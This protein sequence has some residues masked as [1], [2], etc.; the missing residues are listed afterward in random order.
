[1]PAMLSLLLGAG[2]QQ[3]GE[4]ISN[5]HAAEAALATKLRRERPEFVFIMMEFVGFAVKGADP[6][7]C[8]FACQKVCPNGVEFGGV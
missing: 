2:L 5:A 7:Y 6:S 3:A 8:T 1:M 4:G